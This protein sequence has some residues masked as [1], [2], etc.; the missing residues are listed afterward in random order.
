[1]KIDLPY[2]GTG[3]IIN[4][5]PA[6]KDT[7]EFIRSLTVDIDPQDRNKYHKFIAHIF[8]SMMIE[9]RKKRTDPFEEIMIPVYSRLIDK[10]FGRTIKIDVLNSLDCL[11][12]IP[13]DQWAKKS[14]RFQLS[15]NVFEEALRIDSN[16][17]LD[18]W[19]SMLEKGICRF[20][21]V[22]LMNGKRII[23]KKK[24]QKTV[25]PGNRGY[26]TNISPLIKKSIDYFEPCPFNPE[27]IYHLVVAEKQ[28]LESAEKVL[29]KTSENKKSRKYK[30]AKKNKSRAQ[31]IF[32]NDYHALRTILLQHPTLS[33]NRSGNACA[34]F[35]YQVAYIPQ[36]SG[37]LTEINGGFQNGSQPF[38]E[39]FLPESKKMF[40]YDIKSSQAYLLLAE[41]K[42]H[43]IVCPWLVDY[44]DEK[45]DK[46]YYAER[47]GIDV[48][49]WKDCFYALV[50]GAEAKNKEFGSIY[51][52]IYNFFNGKPM[53][54]KVP[55]QRFLMETKELSGA[56]EKW[57]D[58]IYTDNDKDY[59]YKHKVKYWKNACEMRYKEYWIDSNGDLFSASD[60][61]KPIRNKPKIKKL[62]RALAAFILQGQE[63]CFIHNL[64]LLC[65]QNGIPVY[66]NEHDGLITGKELPPQL[67]KTA[68]DNA[69]K[70]DPPPIIEVKEICSDGKRNKMKKH[71][72]KTLSASI[73]KNYTL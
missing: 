71:L 53:K 1:M 17:F 54:A 20:K 23:S 66:K 61:K 63:A 62:K 21:M 50:M 52:S 19:K 64:T 46:S 32:I 4:D 24:H 55:W 14:R 13:Q 11:Y 48:A 70:I 69:N 60:P 42:K 10:E 18:A 51:K 41:L 28:V 58:I 7:Y 72:G 38:K 65:K 3:Y 39:L 2:T 31:G 56:V 36:K 44:L 45:M 47:I 15:E 33:S 12:I 8:A 57:R 40:N 35:K 37:R 9:H 5:Y 43:N 6:P 30:R 16:Y 25:L 22:N 26:N 29:E 27:K 68:A 59:T 34:V 67:V 73:F 49:T